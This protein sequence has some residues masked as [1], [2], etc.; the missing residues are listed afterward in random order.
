MVADSPRASARNIRVRVF[1][2]MPDTN[3]SP[4]P[5]PTASA[6]RP[7]GAVPSA[8]ATPFK[9]S[10]NR[11]HLYQ[12]SDGTVEVS[13]HQMMPSRAQECETARPINAEETFN[14]AQRQVASLVEEITR[15][16]RGPHNEEALGY[17]LTLIADA[18]KMFAGLCA[19]GMDPMMTV[20]ALRMFLLGFGELQE[21]RQAVETIAK[22]IDEGRKRSEADYPFPTDPKVKRDYIHSCVHATLGLFRLIR[23]EPDRIKSR[24]AEKSLW[25]KYRPRIEKLPPL[26]VNPRPWALAI[27]DLLMSGEDGP[28]KQDFEKG[29]RIYGLIENDVKKAVKKR[30]AI[31]K[32]NFRAKNRISIDDFL[33]STDVEKVRAIETALERGA[34][35]R[36]HARAANLEVD[37]LEIR[38]MAPSEADVKSALYE[39]ILEDLKNIRGKNTPAIRS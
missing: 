1:A 11:I 22:P 34:Q 26:A 31:R 12:R 29:G 28:D 37:A 20:R 24:L 15:G 21:I 35:N 23:D 32:Q 3:H 8:A 19:A 38:D 7:T 30:Q 16:P 14:L 36:A 4:V 2:P 18:C 13:I 10:R 9:T 33:K 5:A 39:A 27:R 6:P 17:L 25:G